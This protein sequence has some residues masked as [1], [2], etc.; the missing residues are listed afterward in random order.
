MT[1]KEFEKMNLN[2][3]KETDYKLDKSKPILLM[4][5][6]RSFSKFTKQF[7]A[8]FDADFVRLMNNTAKFLCA[9]I[10]NA[11]H[12]FVQS[13]EISIYLKP[14]EELTEPWFGGRL[15]KICSVAA[16]MASSF[17]MKE[18]ITYKLTANADPEFT[19]ERGIY[20]IEEEI[21]ALPVPT[22]DCKAWNVPT[23]NEVIDWF[24]Y[25][26]KDCVRNS[27]QQFAQTFCSYSEL[28]NKTADEQI[29]FCIQKTDGEQNWNLLDPTLQYGRLISKETYE[30]VHPSTEAIYTRNIWVVKPAKQGMNTIS[31]LI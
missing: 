23:Y 30:I 22:F 8:P 13:D 31:Y 5:D 12:A 14:C 21:D 25:R 10:Q 7:N 1:E 17:F 4:L 20:E 6:G 19:K 18:Y 16:G 11:V 27:K 26:Q 3:R 24:V 28:L 29:L 2:L 15:N 9:N